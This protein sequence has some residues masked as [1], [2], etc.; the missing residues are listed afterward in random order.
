ME[1]DHEADNYYQMTGA[2]AG[3]LSAYA[4]NNQPPR[5]SV[6]WKGG[7]TYVREDHG[8]DYSPDLKT[9]RLEL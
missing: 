2:Y 8:F 7:V 4:W 5:L 9:T 1:F 3:F 6:W